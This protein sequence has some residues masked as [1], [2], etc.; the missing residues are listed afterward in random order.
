MSLL[1]D[2]LSP[3]ELEMA[4]AIPR[5]PQLPLPLIK[6]EMV[7]KL[8]CTRNEQVSWPL[9]KPKPKG[10]DLAK[11]A[12]S[13]KSA[14]N[15]GDVGDEED[16]IYLWNSP[17]LMILFDGGDINCAL[18]YIVESL[19]DPFA[20][21]AVATL[22]IQECLLK[23]FR[24]RLLDRFQEMPAPIAN[25]PILLRSMEK[26][27]ALKAT[28]IVG[29]AMKHTPNLGTPILVCDFTH[30]YLG[31]GPTGVITLHTF[32]TPKDATEVYLKESVK[33]SSVCIW[34]ENLASAYETVARMATVQ[35]FLINC[36]DVDLDPIKAAFIADKN[37]V[38]VYRGYH[39]ETITFRKLRKV[40]VF[41]I[42]NIW[43]DQ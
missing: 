28:T 19:H 4:M 14:A 33:F 17:R 37:M 34:N 26:L 1:S 36:Y 22:L 2:K 3:E 29:N 25:H 6:Y 16:I 15:I 30:N 21:N 12:K 40:I 27:K 5:Y 41:P 8:K 31:A 11:V 38:K 10:V 35:I 43:T 9:V 42:G 13:T 24:D 18:H 23:E 32:R 39:Y 20:E 7:H